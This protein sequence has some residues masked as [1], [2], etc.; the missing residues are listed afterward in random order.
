[1]LNVNVSSFPANMPWSVLRCASKMTA[2]TRTGQQYYVV[3]EHQHKPGS[4]IYLSTAILWHRR[5]G[6]DVPI[7]AGGLML[8]RLP[9]QQNKGIELV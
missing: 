3:G 5:P 2:Q 4:S 7:Y 8:R 9:S 1:M 6:E